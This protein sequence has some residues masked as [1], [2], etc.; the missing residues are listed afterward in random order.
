VA[1]ANTDAKE[2]KRA[3]FDV[4]VQPI[5]PL[6]DPQRV[7][8]R[9]IFFID[10]DRTRYVSV[11]YYPARN[12]DVLLEFGGSMIK[13]IALTEANVRTLAEHLPTLCEKCAVT[14]NTSAKTVISNCL[15]LVLIVPPD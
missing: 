2:L 9:R 4:W 6:F 11:G 14:N 8:L 15:P 1:A 10:S 12:Y 5:G 3:D 13:P 7:L